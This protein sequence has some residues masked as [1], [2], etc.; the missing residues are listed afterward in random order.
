MIA[1]VGT[2]TAGASARLSVAADGR[3]GE[4]AITGLPKLAPGRVYQLWFART[5]A[6]PI[7]GGVFGVDARGEALAVVVVPVALEPARAVA[8]TEEPAPGSPAPTGPHLLDRR[9]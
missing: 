6:A 4:L 7:S 2:G 5:G 3:R 9:I 1:L 8:V